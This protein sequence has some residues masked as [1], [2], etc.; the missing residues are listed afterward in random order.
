[1]ATKEVLAT[2]VSSYVPEGSG[3]MVLL[4]QVPNFPYLVWFRIV[5]G[6]QAGDTAFTHTFA[7]CQISSLPETPVAASAEAMDEDGA[8]DAAAPVAVAAAPAPD[9]NS[10]PTPETPRESVMPEVETYLS[11]LVLTTIM[12]SPGRGPESVAAAEALFG[13][14]QRHNRRSLDGLRAK[15]PPLPSS[16]APNTILLGCL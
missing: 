11:L 4:E 12:R 6:K 16:S 9:A 2:A 15:V 5:T 7:S 13:N 10:F 8:A 3:R 1:M 14:V